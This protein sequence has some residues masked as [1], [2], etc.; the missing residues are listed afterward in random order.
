MLEK[1]KETMRYIER[2]HKF[3]AAMAGVGTG[4]ALGMG[5]LVLAGVVAPPLIALAAIPV[6]ASGMFMDTDPYPV[7]D[8]DCNLN[9]FKLV[10][11][12]ADLSKIKAM[13]EFIDKKTDKL[14]HMG[15]LP[16]QLEARLQR[17]IADVAPVL[18]RVRV[19]KAYAFRDDEKGELSSF[20]FLREFID[21]K[22][23]KISQSLAR[24]ELVPM[25]LLPRSEPA[26][27][28]VEQSPAKQQRQALPA[29]EVLS[30]E[31]KALADKVDGVAERVGVL[32]N[33]TPPAQLEKPKFRA[34][35][36]G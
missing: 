24:V 21:E 28:V 14:K 25:G 3:K 18:Q 35:N 30:G 13:Q 34:N 20:E 36:R 4:S 22:G 17:H 6:F 32:E 10:G 1:L 29:P 12:A 9:G 5:G 26:R 8:N 7:R 19:Y 33:P 23:G 27:L 2:Q 15:R 31:F 16:E 11:D